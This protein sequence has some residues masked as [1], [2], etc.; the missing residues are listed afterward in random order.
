MRFVGRV[1]GIAGLLTWAGAMDARAQCQYYVAPSGS[2]SNPGTSSQPWA[3]LNHASAQVL[4][5]GGSLE[6]Q[7]GG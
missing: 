7:V 1:V 3:T 6:F 5:L 2:D 4:A